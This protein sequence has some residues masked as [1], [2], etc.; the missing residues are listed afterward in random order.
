MASSSDSDGIAQLQPQQEA[1]QLRLRQGEGAFQLDGVLGGQHHERPRQRHGIAVHGH[2][3]LLHGLQQGALGA[4]RGPVD[5]VGQQDLGE[6]RAGTELEGLLLLVEERDSGDVAGQQVGRELDAPE[7]AAQGPGQ[8]L[9]QGG[10]ADAR[11]V[12]QQNVT[13]AEQRHQRK[14]D[15]LAL[16]DDYPLNVRFDLLGGIFQHLELRH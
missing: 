8:A 12:L 13:L 16:A 9:G 3:A 10:L 4:R 6:D 7:A 14:L 1:V 11:H 5:L 15:D 2:L